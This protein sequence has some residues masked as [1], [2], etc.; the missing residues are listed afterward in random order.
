MDRNAQPC[1]ALK[2]LRSLAPC[3]VEIQLEVPRAE[4]DPVELHRLPGLVGDV[5]GNVW[6]RCNVDTLAKA[7]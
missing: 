5:D 6:L 4:Y 1:A 3:G 2:T 7:C